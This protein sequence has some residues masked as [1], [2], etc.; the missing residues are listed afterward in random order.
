MAAMKKAPL[1]QVMVQLT[2]VW[3]NFSMIPMQYHFSVI[4]TPQLK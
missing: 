3:M 2:G 4:Q 1:S